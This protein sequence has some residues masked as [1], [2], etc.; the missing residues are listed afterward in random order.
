[1]TRW[2]TLCLSGL[3][4]YGC[5][6][7][8]T[9]VALATSGP[10]VAGP[11]EVAA[12]GHLRHS[13]RPAGSPAPITSAGLTPAAVADAEQTTAFRPVELTLPSGASAPIVDS[14]VGDDGALTIP[15]DPKVVGIWTG[16]AQPGD[17][18]GAV[19]IAGHI[20]S[21][22]FGIGVLAGL[23]GVQPSAVVELSAGQNTV[24]Y[25]VVKTA[26]VHQQRLASDAELFDQGG[27]PRLV[28]ITCG[29]PF[30]PVKHHY[31]DNF[32]VTARPVA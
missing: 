6:M 20:D 15:D 14:D 1:M 26:L 16:G 29:G 28:I 11:T 5:A 4:I 21:A 7:A 32:I 9:G 2:T 10:P 24:R 12:P 23:K 17:R 27:P 3:T 13:P 25:R 18:S 31:R 30:D 22:R 8:V 19:V